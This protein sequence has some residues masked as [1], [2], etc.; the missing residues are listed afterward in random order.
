VRFSAYARSIRRVVRAEHSCAVVPGELV[1]F[2]TEECGK[3][4]NV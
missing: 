1:E 2:P 3:R 4:R